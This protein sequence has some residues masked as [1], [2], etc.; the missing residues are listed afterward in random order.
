[1]ILEVNH[2]YLVAIFVRSRFLPENSA[3]QS[4]SKYTIAKRSIVLNT[5]VS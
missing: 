1:M 4:F 3:K 2:T 5:S